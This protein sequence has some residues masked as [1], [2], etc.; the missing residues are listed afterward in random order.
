[1]FLFVFLDS[2]LGMGYNSDMENP[3]NPETDH[4]TDALVRCYCGLCDDG[5]NICGDDPLFWED[6]DHEES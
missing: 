5:C 4:L 3:T 2:V 6:P 1:M